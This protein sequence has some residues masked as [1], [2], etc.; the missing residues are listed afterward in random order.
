MSCYLAGEEVIAGAITQDE[1]NGCLSVTIEAP[2]F[3]A[4]QLAACAASCNGG[5]DVICSD[6]T[7]ECS[8]SCNRVCSSSCGSKVTLDCGPWLPCA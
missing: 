2:V 1:N 8:G 4:T 3:T 6:L 5:A 7:N